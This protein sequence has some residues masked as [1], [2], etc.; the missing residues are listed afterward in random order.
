M[1]KK[2]MIVEDER[3][4]AR[5]LTQLLIDEGY[6]IQPIEDTAENALTMIKDAKPDLVIIDIQLLGKMDGIILSEKINQ[7]GNIPVIFV[8]AYT[9]KKVIDR[10]MK[11]KPQ[12]YIMKPILD[13]D[14]LVA[15]KDALN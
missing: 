8:T 9:E 3:I 13:Q 15:V 1:K 5:D 2:I 11:T 4:I 12:A 6:E 7:I 10:A 14:L